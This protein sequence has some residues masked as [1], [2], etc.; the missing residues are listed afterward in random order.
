MTAATT[1][2]EFWETRRASDST[3]PAEIPEA[4]AFGA[5]KEHADSLLQLVLDGTKTG[6]AS[7]V[8]DYEFT[9]ESLPQVGEYSIILDGAGEPRA[10]IVTTSVEI[11]PFDEVTEEHARA[12]GED[13]RT[14]AS[15][16]T[17]HERYWRLHSESPKGYEPD[18]PV[19][20]E[21]FRLVYGS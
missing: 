3:L 5:T 19:L 11:V 21:R 15:W 1:V 17:I 2:G 14:L 20:C 6:T 7:S 4:W 8:W 13:D 16:R 12:E 18:M 10:V 9:G